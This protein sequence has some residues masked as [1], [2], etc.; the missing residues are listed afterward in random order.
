M[1]NTDTILEPYYKEIESGIVP[2]FENIIQRYL[3]L[4][5]TAPTCDEVIC[6]TALLSDL[7]PWEFSAVI[8]VK[9]KEL[10]F[11]SMSRRR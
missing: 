3:F 6:L 2:R 4:I 1:E 9:L 11:A 5:E 10:G 7:Y 8:T